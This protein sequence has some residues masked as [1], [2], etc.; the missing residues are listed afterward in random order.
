MRQGGKSWHT[1]NFILSWLKRED[2]VRRLGFIVTK[3]IGDAVD[4]NRI[5]RRLRPL[6]REMLPQEAQPGDYVVIGKTPCLDA[7]AE[8]LKKDLLWALKKLS[9]PSS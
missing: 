9:Q 2:E 6:L 7:D 1:P 4:R 3:K 8:T 5:K